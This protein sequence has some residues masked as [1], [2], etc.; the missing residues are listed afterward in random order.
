[1][2]KKINKYILEK[3]KISKDINSSNKEEIDIFIDDLI[4]L[5]KKD[6]GHTLKK[7]Y[8]IRQVNNETIIINL[9]YKSTKKDINTFTWLLEKS[10][11]D[12]K[13][14]KFINIDSSSNLIEIKVNFK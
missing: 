5:L 8:K 7:D 11:R 9:L 14:I 6:Y 3:F 2:M 12:L 10:I 13:Y 4:E 1:M